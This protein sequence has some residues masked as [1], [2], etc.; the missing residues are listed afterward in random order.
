MTTPT[1]PTPMQ[2]T[3]QQLDELDALM[4]RML[5]IP[6]SAT[7]EPAPEDLPPPIR[8]AAPPAEILAAPISAIPP[9]RRPRVP[10]RPARNW[11]SG[12]TPA[13]A[14]LQANAEVGPVK[15]AA[16]VAAQVPALAENRPAPLPVRPKIAASRPKIS[17][18]LR[19]LVWCNRAF[20]LGT[21]LLGPLGHGF[22]RPAGRSLLGWTGIL[23]LLS[24]AAWGAWDWMDWTW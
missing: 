13:P 18:W 4:Q 6:I 17:L 20:D 7:D 10:S 16:P 19:P 1:R 22:R 24:A 3:R 8:Q 5:A 23:L 9:V 15:E 21:V 12:A 11:T 14:G 2:P